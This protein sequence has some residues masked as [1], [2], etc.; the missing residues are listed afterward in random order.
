MS[1][2][3]AA[4][5]P[6]TAAPLVSVEGLSVTFA[7]EDG[8]FT[9]V[10]DLSFHIAPGETVAVVGES[11]SGKSVTALSLMRLVELG[12]GRIAKGALNFRFRDGAVRDLV[13]LRNNFV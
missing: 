8:V 11:G 7:G 3:N 12:G 5:S 10:K 6:S 4:S 2:I 9:A 1:V 13:Q